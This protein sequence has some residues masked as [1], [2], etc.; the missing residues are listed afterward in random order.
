[1]L[2]LNPYIPLQTPLG[3]AEAFSM[4][5]FGDDQNTLFYC[6]VDS[7]V[8]VFDSTE[9]RRIKNL[10]SGA[11]ELRPFPEEVMERWSKLK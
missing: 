7:I 11:T 2:Q 8:C 9:V 10:T 4:A 6:F 1:M 3:Y 5:D